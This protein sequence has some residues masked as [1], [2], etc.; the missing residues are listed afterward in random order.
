MTVVLLAV[1][2]LTPYI[3]HALPMNITED[4]GDRPYCTKT[5]DT[6]VITT[7]TYCILKDA[8][9]TLNTFCNNSY[10]NLVSVH[11]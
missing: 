5:T 11:K 8:L 10:Y 9:A 2:V 1:M 4:D 6:S 3:T 7:E